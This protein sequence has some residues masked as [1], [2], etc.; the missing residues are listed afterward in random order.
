[1]LKKN[2][3]RKNIYKKIIQKIGFSKNFSNKI[4]DDFF[5]ILTKELINLNKVK[6]SS[7]GTFDILNKSKRIGRNPKNNKEAI[8]AARKVVRFK[9]SKF[10]RKKINSQ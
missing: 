2:F 6:I 10:L 3:T 7:F 4:V 8:I 5:N 9:A 1:M